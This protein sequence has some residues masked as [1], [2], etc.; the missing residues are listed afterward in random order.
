MT[1]FVASKTLIQALL[2]EEVYHTGEIRAPAAIESLTGLRFIGSNYDNKTGY[3]AEAWGKP[4]E[5][6]IDQYSEITL[7][8]RGTAITPAVENLLGAPLKD[9]ADSD[10]NA[11]IGE[12]AS[13]ILTGNS[14]YSNSG[15]SFLEALQN[16]S[17]D[18]LVVTGHSLGGWAAG[19]L[20]DYALN[21][22][23]ANVTGVAF[24]PLQYYQSIF[25]DSGGLSTKLTN[26]AIANETLTR[27]PLLDF[28]QT[29]SS[30][31]GTPQGNQVLL[32]SVQFA[33]GST[34]EI[35]KNHGADTVV[36]Q[37]LLLLTQGHEDDAEFIAGRNAWIDAAYQSYQ[38]QGIPEAI[39]SVKDGQAA[40]IPANEKLIVDSNGVIRYVAGEESRP[41]ITAAD[42]GRVFGSQLGRLLAG[43]DQFSQIALGTVLGTLGQNIGQEIDAAEGADIVG[44]D[45]FFKDLEQSGIS[46]VGSYLFGELK[47]LGSE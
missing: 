8:N 26:Y 43:D 25:G 17:P 40:M 42:V 5:G 37:M 35:L 33:N 16:Y 46:A 15:R 45:N 22:G 21:R 14:S 12:N 28:T 34:G 2:T 20:T 30:L 9:N 29:F 27:N 3:Y 47:E 41:L 23:Y 7:V 44:F 38:G 18:A 11:E 6:A 19:A 36:A 4:I 1:A 10:R 24:N 31:F 13:I 32:G 39:Q